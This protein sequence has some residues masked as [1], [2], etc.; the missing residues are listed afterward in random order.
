LAE[1]LVIQFQAGSSLSF[2]FEPITQAG[3][4]GHGQVA[5]GFGQAVNRIADPGG[6]C[7]ERIA[8][9]QKSLTH[10]SIEGQAKNKAPSPSPSGGRLAGL[11]LKADL[12]VKVQDGPLILNTDVK[13][14]DRI[15]K[16]PTKFS[17]T[18]S[19]EGVGGVTH[20]PV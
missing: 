8:L 9:G 16:N 19:E 15:G 3:F 17:Y 6:A 13:G 5:L 2:L 12:M 1:G 7:N 20:P 11:K 4:E 14:L 10:G 18:L